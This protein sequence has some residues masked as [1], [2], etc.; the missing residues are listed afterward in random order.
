MQYYELHSSRLFIG[1]EENGQIVDD[2]AIF[3]LQLLLDVKKVMLGHL[4]EMKSLFGPIT[5]QMANT[6]FAV[7]YLMPHLFEYLKLFLN[8]FV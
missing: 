2:A 8:L 4:S 5:S 3:V 7:I 1:T 6:M